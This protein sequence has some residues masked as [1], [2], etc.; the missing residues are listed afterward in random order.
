ML[1]EII[2]AVVGMGWV[3]PNFC[4]LGPSF[5]ARSSSGKE[6]EKSLEGSSPFVSFGQFGAKGIE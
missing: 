2:L 1:W 4:S 5:L 3:F 6:T